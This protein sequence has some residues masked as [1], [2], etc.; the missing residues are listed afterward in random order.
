MNY[1][2]CLDNIFNKTHCCGSFNHKSYKISIIYF[3]QKN[4]NQK[5]KNSLNLKVLSQDDTIS[6]KAH[7]NIVTGTAKEEALPSSGRMPAVHA[8]GY[9]AH[10]DSSK[11]PGHRKLCMRL[12]AFAFIL[13]CKT[14]EGLQHT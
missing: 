3:I 5:N 14:I 1:A 11:A 7:E 8:S 12:R 6:S 13:K 4:Y 2:K 10:W 9:G